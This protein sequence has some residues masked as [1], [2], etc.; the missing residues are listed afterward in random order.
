MKKIR[1]A[2]W[3]LVVTASLNADQW[4]IKR[5]LTTKF[6]NHS[7]KEIAEIKR[8]FSDEYLR[9]HVKSFDSKILPRL[10]LISGVEGNFLVYSHAEVGTTSINLGT[11]KMGTV[12]LM[13]EKPSFTCDLKK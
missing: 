10:E 12:R 13:K 1:I 7:T 9:D 3:L 4:P 11:C 5:K 2:L 6:M 8:W